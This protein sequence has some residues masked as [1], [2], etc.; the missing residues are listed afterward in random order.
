MNRTAME[1]GRVPRP[2]CAPDRTVPNNSVSAYDTL[3]GLP[4]RELVA[5]KKTELWQS[6]APEKQLYFIVTIRPS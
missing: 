5:V 4:K 1:A 3:N 6:E 2:K